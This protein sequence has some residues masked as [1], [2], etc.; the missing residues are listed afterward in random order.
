MEAIK[1]IKQTHKE[2]IGDIDKNYKDED[3]NNYEH[4]VMLYKILNKYDINTETI[5][6]NKIIDFDK[7]DN[8]II[9]PKEFNKLTEIKF[10][11]CQR[12]W[13]EKRIINI[14]IEN[15][16]TLK[17][18]NFETGYSFLNLDD[19]M[20]LDNINCASLKCKNCKI[21]NLRISKSVN[22]ENCTI[23]KLTIDFKN[24]ILKSN[25]IN[26]LIINGNTNDILI[27]NNEIKNIRINNCSCIKNIN[28][29]CDNIKIHT[30][31]YNST[32]IE[33]IK[34]KNL[35]F[36]FYNFNIEF[37]KFITKQ[38]NN[39]IVKYIENDNDIN[40]NNYNHITIEKFNIDYYLNDEEV[41]ICY[42]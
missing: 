3:G 28:C 5:F 4:Y 19:N 29:Q 16:K 23:N 14:Y 11:S 1:F 38:M 15:I 12:L 27:E 35:I 33:N 31:K 42:H 26:K 13:Q 20:D 17:R 40:K 22:C 8:N 10:E 30:N 6:I 41:L 36:R 25:K 18:I 21:K 24:I 37:I 32:K 39:K 9:I 7:K 34:F 2:Y